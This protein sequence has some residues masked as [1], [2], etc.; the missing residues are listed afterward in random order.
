M[1]Q[2]PSVEATALQCGLFCHLRFELKTSK[3][4]VRGVF[5][6]KR[7]T[8]GSQFTR[9]HDGDIIAYLAPSPMHIPTRLGVNHADHVYH[10]KH[11][12]SRKSCKSRKWGK[13]HKTSPWPRPYLFSNSVCELAA[14]AKGANGSF[15]FPC[16]EEDESWTCFRG[17]LRWVRKKFS[18]IQKLPPRSKNSM[19]QKK[20]STLIRFSLDLGQMDWEYHP[21]WCQ[22]SH[23]T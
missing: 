12:K 6:Q 17:F 1:S 8:I 4:S 9:R 18:S 11:V 10:A 7:F 5:F 19:G 21:F 16:F 2:S 13:F 14:G 23:F 3:H 15:F 22:K 20:R